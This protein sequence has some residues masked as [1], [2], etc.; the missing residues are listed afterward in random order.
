MK[1]IISI[2]LVFFLALN[3][4]AQE[5]KKNKNAKIEF[6]VD[7]VCGMC[8]KRIEKAALS[9]SGVKLAVWNIDSGNL[10]L[11]IN[12]EKTNPKNIQQAIANIGHD[13]DGQKTT[14]EAYNSLHAC[15]Q[16]ER[17]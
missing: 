6:H 14:D 3:I 13:N 4:N 16:Y 5:I 7:G 15:C 12:E 9:V 11:I 17:K 1:N 8:K 2:I 10:N